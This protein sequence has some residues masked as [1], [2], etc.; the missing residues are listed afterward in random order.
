ME[1]DFVKLNSDGDKTEIAFNGTCCLNISSCRTHDAV[2]FNDRSVCHDNR[3]Y[4]ERT[5]TCTIAATQ[6]YWSSTGNL[7][8]HA[9]PGSNDVLIRMSCYH[10]Q[11]GGLPAFLGIFCDRAQTSALFL[12]HPTTSEPSQFT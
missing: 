10:S 1:K 6:L 9:V 7:H 4:D 5:D 2:C 8:D 11:I 12:P 3:W